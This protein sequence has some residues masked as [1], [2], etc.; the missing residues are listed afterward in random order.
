[1]FI[2]HRTG[3]TAAERALATRTPLPQVRLFGSAWIGNKALGTRR[4]IASSLKLRA[5]Q[6]DPAT[7][8]VAPANHFAFL[9]HRDGAAERTGNAL[10]TLLGVSSRFGIHRLLSH[11]CVT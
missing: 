6:D 1:M 4:V 9:L 11:R 8:N 10:V 5:I 3:L 7:A 2:V